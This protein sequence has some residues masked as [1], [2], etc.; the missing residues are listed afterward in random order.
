MPVIALLFIGAEGP[1]PH[2]Q[3][4]AGGRLAA[5]RDALALLQT[6]PGLERVIVATPDR[7]LVS[8]CA[9]WAVDWDFDSPAEPFHFGRRLAG[10]LT[11]AEGETFFYLGAGSLPLLPRET[12]ARACD[13]ALASPT[14]LA[15]TNNPL[16]SDWMIFNC[17]AA[18]RARPARLERDN[19]LGPVLAFEAGVE[20]RGLP[21]S[22][23]ARLDIDTPADLLLLSLL[24]DTR[25][26]LAEYLRLNPRD[27]SRWQ[28]AV[29]V[30]ATPGS[31]V[32]FIGR[33]S[34]AVW[35]H[36]EKHTR[37]WTRVFSE[38]RGMSASGRQAQGQVHSLV[39]AH[40]AHVGP[41][42]F[43]DELSQIADAVFFDTRVALAH[44]RRWPTAAD[45]YASDLGL[46]DEVEDE[47]LR[48]LTRAAVNA[49]MPVV[50]GGHGVVAGD[51]Y[52]AV[53]LA[54]NAGR[55]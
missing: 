21:A 3:W 51:M 48:A 40:L 54:R 14:P 1:G 13:E 4:V 15:I 24:P 9:D 16:S 44:H 49:P 6:L 12:L 27:A 47:F 39:A 34:A 20:V 31:R 7:S 19:M 2:E 33:V 17:P 11:D 42:A 55:A 53:E 46:P 52:G 28:S 38:E 10:L 30:L 18:V 32:T 36:V 23:A 45:R 5:A 50:L 41:R 8:R 29:D 43:F 26:A 22:A 37:V 35:G 25:P